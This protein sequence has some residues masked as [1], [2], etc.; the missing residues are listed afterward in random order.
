M[1]GQ[2]RVLGI[3]SPGEELTQA[4]FLRRIEGAGGTYRETQ[5]ELSQGGSGGLAHFQHKFPR[6][7]PVSGM[8]SSKNIV[9]PVSKGEEACQGVP[10]SAR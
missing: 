2:A 8:A 3:P 7:K 5:A 6:T 1:Y 10:G 9:L 4:A